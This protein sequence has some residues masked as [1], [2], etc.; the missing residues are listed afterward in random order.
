MSIINSDGLNT[1]WQLNVLRGLQNIVDELNDNINANL[2]GPLGPLP[3][4]SSISVALAVDQF[5]INVTPKIISAS[6]NALVLIPDTI[7]SIS[8]AS[9]GTDNAI[10]TFDG[11]T[12]LVRL[13][14]GTTVNMDAGGVGNRYQPNIFGY[15]TLMFPGAQVLVT[16]N[17]V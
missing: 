16:Y 11:G 1:N 12:T 3:V 13:A 2:T 6:N 14:P 15:D 5:D 4:T 10:V 9:V 17:Y 7:T 8:I